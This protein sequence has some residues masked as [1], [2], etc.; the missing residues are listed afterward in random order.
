MVAQPT[1]PDRM[2]ESGGH[3]CHQPDFVSHHQSRD[4]GAEQGFAA[5]PGVVHELEEGEVEIDEVYVVAGHKGHPAAVAK[6]GASADTG[7]G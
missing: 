7:G 4:E 5:A 3:R 1:S 2:P 6:R